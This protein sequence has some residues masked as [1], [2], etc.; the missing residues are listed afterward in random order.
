MN[1]TSLISRARRYSDDEVVP[2]YISDDE[3][4]EYLT[5]A[6]RVLAKEGELL[7]KLV[8]LQVQPEDQWVDMESAGSIIEVR[9]ATLVDP[10]TNQRYNL[11]TTGSMSAPPESGMVDG[12]SYALKRPT[13]IAFGVTST[14]A[15]L[16]AIP[17]KAY[18][19]ELMT[20][21]Y[22]TDPIT[23]TSEEPEIP[24]KY[25]KYIP[26]GAAVFA[27]IGS[28]AEHFDSNRVALV[29]AFWENGVV[30]A[31]AE[32]NK[33]TRDAGTVQLVNDYWS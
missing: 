10:D 15:M 29:R 23:L 16:D 1:I 20:I 11:R 6:E 18:T 8:Y 25:H 14:H 28:E 5:E 22:P 30:E 19:I 2:Y 33:L 7:R 9:R 27:M 24:E 17:P 4:C 26:Y 31:V 21:S 3:M 13:S 12:Y 32:S